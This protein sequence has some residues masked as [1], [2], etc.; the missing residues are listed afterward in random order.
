MNEDLQRRN[1]G[2]WGEDDER[3]AA[4]LITPES[5]LAAL[6]LPTRGQVY[7]LAQ[8]LTPRGVPMDLAVGRPVHF[9]TL[10]G[11]DFADERHASRVPFQASSDFLAMHMH[12]GTHID[13]LGHFFYD[14]RL[15]N[16]FDSQTIH[17]WGMRYLGIDRAGPFL[18]RGVLLD[19]AGLLGVKHLEQGYTISPDELQAA[20]AAGAVTIQAGDAVLIRTGWILSYSSERPH[21]YGY[22]HPGIG[23][24]AAQW[25]ADRDVV[26]VGSDNPGV[27]RSGFA[28]GEEWFPVH[29]F[30]LR[31]CGIYLL[32]YLD[33]E[34]LAAA[35]EHEFLFVAVPLQLRGGTGSPITPLAIV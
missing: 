30:L 24:E 8:P 34:E 12:Q 18:T 13:S 4:N 3:G 29:K 11:G 16:G 21:E 7:K 14:G 35:A 15:Y 31:D 32:E 5:L 33:L 17:S 27:E 25:L 20:A 9:L 1:W 28:E 2:R 22:L 23:L 19:L 26:L 6:R 10:D